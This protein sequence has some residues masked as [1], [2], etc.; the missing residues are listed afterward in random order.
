MNGGS[1]L[2]GPKLYDTETTK[3]LVTRTVAWYKKYR[4]IL[5]ADV[6]H[7]RRPDGRD[8]DGILHISTTAKN[9]GISL[10]QQSVKQAMVRTITVPLYYT[11]LNKTVSVR[12]RVGTAV[13]HKLDREYN[14]YLRATIPLKDIPGTQP[15][16]RY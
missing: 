5:N 9:K 6:I 1:Q 11:G 3:Q 15:S 7:L 16:N 14:I 4:D 2:P 13:S 10:A 8:W 12:E